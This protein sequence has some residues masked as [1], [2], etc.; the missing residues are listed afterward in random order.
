[1]DRILADDFVLATGAAKPYT[2]DDLFAE[3]RLI[4]EHSR[5]ET[6]ERLALIQAHRCHETQGYYFSRPVVSHRFAKLRETGIPFPI[7][8]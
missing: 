1:M 7:L 3:A 6:Q 2:K 4:A 5:A 8:E